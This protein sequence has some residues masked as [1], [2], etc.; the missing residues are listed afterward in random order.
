[1]TNQSPC[2][3][4]EKMVA[5]PT[6]EVVWEFRHSIAFLG[7]WQ[8]YRGYCV[9][10]AR[11]HAAELF[12]L[13]QGVRR[14]YLDEMCLLAR[15]IAET[16]QPR[17]MNYELLGNQVPHLHWHLFPRFE[18][19]PHKLQ[20]VWGAIDQADADMTRKVLERDGSATIALLRERLEMLHGSLT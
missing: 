6:G 2:S 4:C 16:F 13:D 11:D 17:K 8:M 12:L 14:S 18:Q 3:L 10:V 15:A 7:P 9:L 20:P 19:D 1:M 5:P